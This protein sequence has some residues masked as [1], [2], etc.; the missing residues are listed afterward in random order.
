[1]IQVKDNIFSFG[2]KTVDDKVLATFKYEGDS[3]EIHYLSAG[4]SC[5]K[6]IKWDKNKKEITFELDL[7]KVGGPNVVV[8]KGQTIY[9]D[10]QEPEYIADENGKRIVNPKKRKIYT[11]IN[12]KV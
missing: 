9:L 6:L 12:G 4:C 5:S 1:M 10:P 7:S 3:D 11:S 2:T 8:N